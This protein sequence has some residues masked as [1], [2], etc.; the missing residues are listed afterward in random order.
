MRFC[1][2]TLFCVA[3]TTEA[4]GKCYWRTHG[5]KIP[6]SLTQQTPSFTSVGPFPK[7]LQPSQHSLNRH[8]CNPRHVTSR[9]VTSRIFSFVYVTPKWPLHLNIPTQC[10]KRFLVSLL[11]ATFPVNSD[12][13]HLVS[14]QPHIHVQ[15]Y[16]NTH[17]LITILNNILGYP[18]PP[19]SYRTVKWPMR[20][21]KI[22]T[23]YRKLRQNNPLVYINSR[24][25]A[26]T[27]KLELFWMQ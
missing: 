19:N 4:Q 21:Q 8:S 10:F 23:N 25:L 14:Q 1:T 27:K 20:V 12:L 6:C 7:W 3:C 24:G 15:M 17:T 16:T 22:L 9:H 18:F 26:G 11:L 13:F 2:K 5:L